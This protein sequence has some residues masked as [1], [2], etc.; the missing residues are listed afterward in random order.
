MPL[1]ARLVVLLDDEEARVF[2]LRAG[3]GLQ[4]DRGKSRSLGRLAL[5]PGRQVIELRAPGIDKGDALRSLAPEAGAR[6]ILFAGDDLGEL[7]A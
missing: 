4:R 3:V 5:E 1:P 7:P 6:P 2:A